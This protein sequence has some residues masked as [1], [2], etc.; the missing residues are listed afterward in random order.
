MPRQEIRKLVHVYNQGLFGT[1]WNH[2]KF[3]I[4]QET[5]TGSRIIHESREYKA[6]SKEAEQE[7]ERL[8][9]TL[10]G[11][12]WGIVESTYRYREEMYTREIP[13]ALPNK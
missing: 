3:R 13:D 2:F 8:R 12:G 5:P 9:A 10:L 1:D 6:H 4:V 7:W 11:E